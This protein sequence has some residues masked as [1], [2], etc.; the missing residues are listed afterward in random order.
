[1]QVCSNRFK[2]PPFTSMILIRFGNS[3]RAAVKKH[4]EYHRGGSEWEF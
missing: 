1:M 3:M 4:D 2:L